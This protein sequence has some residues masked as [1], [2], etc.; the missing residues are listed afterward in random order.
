MEVRVRGRYVVRVIKFLWHGSV[1]V[2]SH[3]G[4]RS[5][6]AWRARCIH[7]RRSGAQKQ[8]N[9]QARPRLSDSSSLSLRFFARPLA[10]RARP[11]VCLCFRGALRHQQL[12]PRAYSLLFWNFPD[13]YRT[14]VHSYRRSV[15]SRRLSSLL[16][17]PTHSHAQLHDTKPRPRRASPA[18]SAS[19]RVRPCV[20]SYRICRRR[21]ACRRLQGSKCVCHWPGVF[22]H[23]VT[24][25]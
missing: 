19:R 10:R 25:Y 4:P 13:K 9:F 1:V 15:G 11:A 8:C 22:P 6:R 23:Y 20:L 7:V 18:L 17:G 3:S 5:T 12:K 21:G 2:E 24:C 16:N 14:T